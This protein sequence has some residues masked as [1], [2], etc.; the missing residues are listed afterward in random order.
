ML[1]HN[2]T[3]SELNNEIE[4]FDMILIG[5]GMD[6]C[7]ETADENIII[8][9]YNNL[10]EMING[11]NY[12][13]VTLKTDDLIY[14]SKL[15]RDRIVAP[16]GSINRFQCSVGCTDELWD[17]NLGVCPHCGMPL[18][19]NTIKCEKYIEKGYIDMWDKYMK[20]LMGTVGKKLLALE[21]DVTMMYPGVIRWAFEKTVN[22]NNKAKMIRINAELPQLPI[23]LK[24]KGTAVKNTGYSLL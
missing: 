9:K 4:E 21:I 24:D 16:C 3:I 2:F 20:W 8:S 5:I 15:D 10:F 7:C 19:E 6:F 23:E 22:L 14:R 12:Y 11:K 17:E 13:I 18:C 1:E